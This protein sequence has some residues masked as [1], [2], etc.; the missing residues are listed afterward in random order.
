MERSPI[1]LDLKV[2]ECPASR[3][4][5]FNEECLVLLGNN[6]VPGVKMC[7][8]F[9]TNDGYCP[10]LTGDVELHQSVPWRLVR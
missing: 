4:P 9:N 5:E 10:I 6:G 1:A 2:V 3:C 8:L 7:W